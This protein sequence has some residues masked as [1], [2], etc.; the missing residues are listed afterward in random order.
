MNNTNIPLTSGASKQIIDAIITQQYMN[1]LSSFATGNSL[2]YQIVQLI[3]CL[4]IDDIRKAAIDAINHGKTWISTC[5]TWLSTKV[6][7]V[8]FRTAPPPEKDTHALNMH[9]YKWT[10][11][12]ENSDML[13]KHIIDAINKK[14]LNGEYHKFGSDT[15][16]LTNLKEKTVSYDVGNIQFNVDA[17]ITCF[18]TEP[19]TYKISYKNSEQTLNNIS[20]SIPNIDSRFV[21]CT[22]PKP[23]GRIDK[24]LFSGALHQYIK[25]ICKLLHVRNYTFVSSKSKIIYDIHA[26]DFINS[27]L[28]ES[29]EDDIFYYCLIISIINAMIDDSGNYITD[30]NK[31]DFRSKKNIINWGCLLCVSEYNQN[32]VKIGNYGDLLPISAACA[33]Q[34]DNICTL[35]NKLKIMNPELFE[36]IRLNL[37]YASRGLYV[38]PTNLE[39]RSEL[40]IT[41]C[42][43]GQ[44]N[45]TKIN[46]IP[47]KFEFYSNNTPTEDI[48]TAVTLWKDAFVK[49]I[50]DTS[51]LRGT[52]QKIFYISTDRKVT[53]ITKS[54]PAYDEWQEK[55]KTEDLKKPEFMERVA[56]TDPPPPKRLESI[57]V[58]Y[59][60]V[61]K[62]MR[63]VYKPFNTLYLSSE[64]H[65]RIKRGIEL[66][67]DKKEILQSM[68]L[69]NKFGLF[70]YGPPGTG[71]T[72]TIYAVASELARPVF[73]VHLKNQMTCKEF[74]MIL[75]HIYKDT[76]GGGIVVFED[77]D[78]MS[79]VVLAGTSGS[80]GI[81]NIANIGSSDETPLSLSYFL[82]VLDGALT[83]DDSVIICTTNHPELLHEAFMRIGRFDMHIKLD[84]ANHDQIRAVAR[85][86]LTR[87]IPSQIIASIPEYKWSTSE[88]IFR[89]K[90]YMLDADV[91]DAHIFAP[92]MTS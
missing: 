72:S 49:N 39:E 47:S 10:L 11:C 58:S 16:K 38:M 41:Y 33:D 53:T 31:I 91:T 30:M 85:Q 42:G 43:P 35:I 82:N 24:L 2:I 37:Y 44:T 26:Y 8:S 25:I 77:V 7:N 27:L 57:T 36:K 79:N 34:Q 59:D 69:P 56:I 45:T 86:M 64:N 22:N 70:L 46:G 84:R 14:T 20:Q 32:G 90:D 71:K 9:G 29:L 66:F 48:K 55:F 89:I 50:S 51:N 63:E 5:Y 87:D 4:S 88:I 75:D 83:C 67:R 17:N 23:Y 12:I 28:P 21:I 62:E 74:Q 18:V 61:K 92:F 54:N 60:L 6:L 52:K 81:D 73:Y 40:V 80:G 3:I 13:L 19:Q 68:G 1:I 65:T 76:V 78:V 15:W